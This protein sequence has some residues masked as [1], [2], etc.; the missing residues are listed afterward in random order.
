MEKAKVKQ[1]GQLLFY[2]AAVIGLTDMVVIAT[3][4]GQVEI[5][6]AALGFFFGAR[7]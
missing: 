4:S 6:H 2:V 7:G 3:T 5:I 1:Y